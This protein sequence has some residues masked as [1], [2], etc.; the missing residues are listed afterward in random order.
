MKRLI[1]LLF[2]SGVLCA[3]EEI[4]L[5]K[6]TVIRTQRG[7]VSVKAGAV[8]EVLSRDEKT[9]TVRFNN[10]T[11]TI[12]AASVTAAPEPKKKAETPA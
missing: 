11:G 7:I 2:L 6:A 5:P 4:T 12:P 9:L 10:I 1:A 8:V 3:A